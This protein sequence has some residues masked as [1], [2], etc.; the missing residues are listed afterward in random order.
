MRHEGGGDVTRGLKK[1]VLFLITESFVQLH[2]SFL[3]KICLFY[4]IRETSLYG[5]QIII[6]GGVG[7]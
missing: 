3:F 4:N 7:G 1:N 2:F 5:K 6:K